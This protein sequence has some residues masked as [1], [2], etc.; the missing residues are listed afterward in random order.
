VHDSND[1][2]LPAQGSGNPPSYEAIRTRDS[3]YVEYATGEREFY[4]LARDP[5]E[6]DNV[7]AQLPPARLRR[8]H[9]TLAQIEACHGGTACWRAQHGAT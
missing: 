4:D 5:F 2:D 8:L 3:L 7:A 1:P 9:R 6:L